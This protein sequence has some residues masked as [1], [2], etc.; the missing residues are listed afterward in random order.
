ML[1]PGQVRQRNLPILWPDSNSSPFGIW[2]PDLKHWNCLSRWMHPSSTGDVRI[3]LTTKRCNGTLAGMSQRG[4]GAWLLWNEQQELPL[5]QNKGDVRMDFISSASGSEGRASFAFILALW[6]EPQR[7]SLSF[8]EECI[9]GIFKWRTCS[10]FQS[11]H[12][13]FFF[14]FF[15]HLKK[16]Q[17]KAHILL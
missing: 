6:W 15:Q 3:A 10:I 11:Y 12:H 7:K 9:L 16:C 2:K 5:S 17:Y 4:H 14:R 8:S 13:L 1:P